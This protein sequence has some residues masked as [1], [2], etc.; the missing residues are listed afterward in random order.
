MKNI[1]QNI[2]TGLKGRR[3]A[4]IDF[5]LKRVGLAVC[6]EF[7][8]TVSP[9]D[10][11]NYESPEF[12]PKLIELLKDENIYA[13]VVGV[14]LRPDGIENGILPRIKEFMKD[15]GN[16]TGLPVIPYDESYSSQKAVATMI[17]IGT[18]KKKRRQKGSIDRV[19]AAIILKEFLEEIEGI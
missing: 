9:R 5:G 17:E 11:M 4:A 6:D 18:P 14:P 12:W 7:H 1:P 16:K 15:L 10:T 2:A 3:I 19:A 13:V 8:I